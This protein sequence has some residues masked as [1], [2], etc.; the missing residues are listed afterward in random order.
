LHDRHPFPY[1]AAEVADFAREVTD[2]NFRIQVSD[3]GFH[4]YNRRGLH[5]AR[6]PYDVFTALGVEADGAHAFYL[7][8]ELARAQIAWQLGKRYNQDEELGW[9][10]VRPAPVSDKQH[11]AAE[12]STLQARKERRKKKP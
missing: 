1:S 5:T 11:F 7:G 8:L 2:D 4:I 6:D 9:G 10:C 12:K 3:E